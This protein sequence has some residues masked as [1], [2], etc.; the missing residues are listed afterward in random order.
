[1]F[2][3][4]YVRRLSLFACLFI[5]QHRFAEKSDAELQKHRDLSFCEDKG[6]KSGVWLFAALRLFKETTGVFSQFIFGCIDT[7]PVKKVS[8]SSNGTFF[9]LQL[10]KIYIHLP[11]HYD[12]TQASGKPSKNR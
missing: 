7:S 6:R 10:A 12:K 5:K 3:C 2:F 11:C 9:F 1:M 4:T 8:H